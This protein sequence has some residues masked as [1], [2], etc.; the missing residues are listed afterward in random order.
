MSSLQTDRQGRISRE[1]LCVDGYIEDNITLCSRTSLIDTKPNLKMTFPLPV[2]I[3]E[4]VIYF[5]GVDKI[6]LQLGEKFQIMLLDNKEAVVSDITRLLDRHVSIVPLSRDPVKY[7]HVSM[8]PNFYSLAICEFEVYGAASEVK[9]KKQPPI[10]PTDTARAS[11]DVQGTEGSGVSVRRQRSSSS[12]DISDVTD[13]LGSSS[14]GTDA[15]TSQG[16]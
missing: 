11:T 16:T 8:S 9:S 15:G 14:A 6:A 5:G 4:I 2:V 7:I 3:D 12:V 10:A 13:Y 1:T